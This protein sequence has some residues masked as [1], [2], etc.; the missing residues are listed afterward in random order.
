MPIGKIEAFD[1]INGD[2]NAYVERVEQYFIANGIKEEKQVA[3]MLSLMGNKTYGL[4]RNLSAP[5]KPSSLSFKDIVE[6]LQKHLSPKPLLIAERF[7]FHKRNQL[8]GETVSKYLAELK[9]L[10]LYCEFRENLNDAIRD[11][12]VCGLHNELI[13][14]RL[15]S[16]QDSS[17]AKASEIALAM[18]AAAKDTRELQGTKES[19]VNKISKDSERVQKA[20]DDV[21]S[22]PHCYRCGGSTHESSE[23]Y[24][25]NEKCRKCGKIGHIQRVCRSGKGQNFTRRRKDENPNLHSFEMDDELNDDS[26]IASLEVNNVDQVEVSDVIWLTP[27][28]NGHPLKMEL[29]TGSAIST[30]PLQKYK[31]MFPD[32]PLV[33]TTAILKTY[34]GEKITPEG[35]LLVRV[36]HNNQVRNLTLYVVKTQG[37]AL[38]GRD[39]L[40]QI[41]LNWKLICA[42]SKEQPTQ[43]TQMKLEKL[44][45]KYSGVFKDEIGTL[46]STKA[47]LVL[48][49]GSQPKFCK[50]RPV[51]YAMKPK[52]G[53]ELKRLEGEGIL[54][55]VKFSDWSTPIVPVVKPNGTVR[56]CGDFKNTV[57]PQ[58]QTEEY[59]LPRIDD[60]FAKLAGG[61]KFTKID[62]R[63]AYHQMEVEEESKEYLTIN[64]HQ[65]LYRYDRLVFGITSAPAIW[66]RSM[67]Q[68]LEG[69]K[70][71]SCILDDMIITGRN[72]QEH[73]DNLEE[74]LKRLQDNGL[75]A[76]HE[77]C[78]FFQT[79]ITYCGHKVDKHGLHKTQEKVDAVV[80]A[81]RPENVHQVRAFLGLVNHY[82]KFLPNLATIL[83]PLNG[84]LEQGKRWKWT[85]ECEEA[86]IAVKKLITSDMVLTH[87]DPER[88]LRLACDASPVGIGAVL[89]HIM[90]D[91]SERPIAFAS[92][93]LTK[94]ERNYSQ[95]DKEALALIWGV[96]KF[97]L[98]LFGRHFTLVTDHEPLTSIFHPKKGIP[99]M[100]VARLQRYA[101]FLAG[102]EYSIEYKNTT[103]HG[104]ADG[105]SRLPLKTSYNNEVVDPVEIFQVSQIDVLPVNADMIRQA[106][107]RDPILSRVVEY[108]KQ[109]WPSVGE[110]ELEP[111]HRRKDELTIQD[112]CLMW[113]SR[114]VIPAKYHAQLLAEI[115][116]GHLGVVKMKALARSYMWWPGMDREIEQVAKGCTGCQITQN[117]PKIAPLHSWEW[118]ARP[119]QR[120]HIDFAGPFLGTMFL[121]IVDAHSK[122]PEVV[123][124]TTTSATR[125]IEELRRLFATHGLPEQLVSDNGPQFTAD[126]FGEF[127]RSNGIKHIRSAPYHPATNGLA[128]RFVQT[129]KQALRAALTEK[130]SISWKLANFLMAYRTTPH[131]TTGETPA[132]LLMGRNIRTKLDVL[133][134]NI[135]KRVEDKQQDQE[136][137]SSHSPTRELDVGQ[138]VVARDYR[139]GKKWVPGV[140][141]AKYGPLSY[142]VRVAPNTVW[143]RHVDQLRETAVTLDFD[144]EHCTPQLDPAVFL[145]TPQSTSSVGNEG[146]HTPTMSDPE[147]TSTPDKHVSNTPENSPSNQTM[148][149][150][151]VNN[152]P[153]SSPSNQ[154]EIMVSSPAAPPC[155]RY[156]LRL[157]KPPEKLNL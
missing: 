60:I 120:I 77:K 94:A 22:K 123:P 18:E 54:H 108:T 102:F 91:G 43:D 86:F 52:V 150:K 44:L 70:G 142:E 39:W 13:Q 101:L 96:K 1:E 12:P 30:L 68:I 157:R 156:P 48:K 8:E 85:T 29:D 66:Q 148:S 17:L 114:V 98:Y 23:C 137:R 110:K 107:Q 36:E 146:L 104:N 112:G 16:E 73:L 106:T 10:S 51:P 149:D 119:W 144:K 113:G 76:N 84:L 15:L 4:L 105:L 56:I 37:P 2:W 69:V 67:D 135:R 47:K 50:A 59:P 5:E 46:K 130:K 154:S 72:D 55:K 75:R 74:V 145:A 35:K 95:I 136:L 53:V 97:H 100:T 129:F 79:K 128:E 80:N 139:G 116:E 49:G 140:I 82:H 33:D 34:S 24:Y 126:E 3:V 92:R 152:T 6:T 65:G 93:T 132:M 103:Q 42:I 28:V 90:E 88:P 109:G 63:Q 41:Q 81:P 87:Y 127:L 115:H 9:K 25:R 64:T 134:P 58:L 45:D 118:P 151:H 121:I 78:E 111:F 125:T 133:K 143:R 62:L 99:A 155:R 40:H 138:T 19:E 122:W 131:A 11:R 71:T 31:E 57:N 61:Q 89:S 26:L 7:R 117:N 124:M 147:Q 27:I 141:T 38:F 20:K 21:K 32:T 14:K 153:E 83:N